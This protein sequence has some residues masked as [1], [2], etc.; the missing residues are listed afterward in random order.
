LTCST[1]AS[2]R[3]WLPGLP[4]PPSAFDERPFPQAEFGD[5]KRRDK[6][7]RLAGL[8]IVVDD[9]E[10]TESFVQYFKV[11]AYRFH[12]SAPGFMAVHEYL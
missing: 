3:F 7:V 8:V 11:S 10:K 6:C 4:G 2:F 12:G 5:H 1:T 9:P